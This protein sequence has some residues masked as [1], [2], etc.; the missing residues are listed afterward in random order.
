MD[1][2][3]F[4]FALADVSSSESGAITARLVPFNSPA[5]MGGADVH[6][7]A[8][9]LTLPE[10]RSVPL[11]IDHGPSVLDR[12]G[13]LKSY[14]ET[15]EAAFGTFELADT[16]TA[17]EV[18]TLLEAGAVGDI[19][20]G[21]LGMPDAEGQISGELDHVSIVH[22]GRFAG[23]SAPSRV[24]SVHESEE[25]SQMDPKET[26]A[27]EVLE[28]SALETLTSEHAAEISRIHQ[29]LDELAQAF[30]T[31]DPREE[32]TSEHAMEVFEALIMRAHGAE[33]SE[34][35]DVVGDLGTADASGLSPDW[36]WA[37]GLQ[38]NTDRR[39]P[40]T[41]AAGFAPFPEY[42]NN[43]SSAKVT[44]EVT[45]GSAA[46]KA[47]APSQSLF[48]VPTQFPV[49]WH[50]GFVDVALELISQSSPEVTGVITRSFLKQYAL[51]S[52]TS[53]EA[54]ARAAATATGAI[55]PV[56]TYANLVAA[57]I[58]TSNDI[59][60]AT[61]LPGDRL[62]VS[63][64]QWGSILGLMD[65]GDRR[66]FAVTGPQNSDGQG[67]L[68]V[69]GIDVGGIFI[70]RDPQTTTAALQFNTESLRVA[71]R[72]PVSVMALNVP[73]M[74]QDQGIIGAT[75]TVTWDEGIY[76]YAAV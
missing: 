56:D 12:I 38:H 44:Q 62:A 20:V 6:F 24:I 25:E 43:I 50:K 23:A 54:A 10:G 51:A 49:A 11:T 60:D 39:R 28:L 37:A 72:N 59:E 65:G 34:H 55:L 63:P 41:A 2:Q 30:P 8:G 35:A 42:G 73:K 14:A 68:T 21:V 67:D 52:N 40:L 1:P 7:E 29:S 58:A 27:A 36:Y 9:G 71:E 31:T 70:F 69:R 16:N 3:I 13:V 47:D 22:R 61:G 18:R 32:I 76:R 26:P 4:T 64:T 57:I 17:Q 45:V 75:A 19:S 48:V 46:Q 53:V 33:L 74:G 15:D 66:Q 5:P